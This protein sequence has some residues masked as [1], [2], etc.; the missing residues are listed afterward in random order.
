MAARQLKKPTDMRRRYW[1][2]DQDPLAGKTY[3]ELC[4]LGKV[5][6]VVSHKGK[7]K[8]NLVVKVGG[9]IVPRTVTL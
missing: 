5:T 3:A 1:G 6:T 7:V 4:R 9:K 2:P 8:V